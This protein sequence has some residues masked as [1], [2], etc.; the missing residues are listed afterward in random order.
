MKIGLTTITITHRLSDIHTSDRVMVL[1]NGA[2][3]E[4][5]THQE[6]MFI[7]GQYYEVYKQQSEH[8]P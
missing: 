5:G 3:V 1:T 7:K 6:L 2:L 4:S 8:Y